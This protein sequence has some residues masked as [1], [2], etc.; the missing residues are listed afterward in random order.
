LTDRSLVK[1]FDVGPLESSEVVAELSGDLDLA[2]VRSR[3]DFQ[4][5]LIELPM[6]NAPVARRD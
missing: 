2:P 3:P 5:L 1:T 6:S 4:L